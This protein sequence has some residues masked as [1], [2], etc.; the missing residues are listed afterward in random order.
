MN[1]TVEQTIIAHYANT[2]DLATRLIELAGGPE[3][4]TPEKLSPY[5]EMHVGGHPATKHLLAALAL[6]PAMRVLDIGC[7]VGGA[8]RTAATLTGAHIT[9]LDLTPDFCATATL[10][11][12]LTGQG[13]QLAFETGNATAMKFPDAIFDAAY[14]IHAAMNIADK[15]SL[16]NEIFRVLKPGAR[17]ALYDIMRGPSAAAPT[18]PLPWASTAD[19]SFLATPEQITAHLANAGF[20]ILHTESRHD[21]A[22]AA[23]TKMTGKAAQ[24]RTATRGP[25]APARYEN[26]LTALQSNTCTACQIL[27]AKPG[28]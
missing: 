26:L 1:K 17:F 28:A 21:F 23:M 7:G 24:I 2:P 12:E 11:S 6:T 3:N 20:T 9:G 16:Y 18:Y 4:L 10:L 14:T 13:T 19:S 5:D 22:V 27:C 15:Q 8:A 25:E